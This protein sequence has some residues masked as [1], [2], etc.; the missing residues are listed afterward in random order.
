MQEDIIVMRGLHL[1]ENMTANPARVDNHAKARHKSTPNV[2]WSRRGQKELMGE[3]IGLSPDHPLVD[4]TLKNEYL[5]DGD[6]AERTT[7]RKQFKIISIMVDTGCA[8]TIIKTENENF[9]MDSYPSPAVISGFQGTEKVKGGVRG[10]V[11]LY[12][13][14]EKGL[15]ANEGG[16][17]RHQVDTLE[18]LNMNLLSLSNLYAREDYDMVI[19]AKSTGLSSGFTKE[20]PNGILNHLPM[21]WDAEAGAFKI[22]FLMA[23]N[24]RDAISWGRKAE[25]YMKTKPQSIQRCLM[26]NAG[27]TRR[28]MYGRDQS[29]TGVNVRMTA[30]KVPNDGHG[31]K[32][33]K[34]LGIHVHKPIM[35][36]RTKCSNEGSMPGRQRTCDCKFNTRF[37]KSLRGE[38][39]PWEDQCY[40]IREDSTRKDALSYSSNE[41]LNELESRGEQTY[42]RNGICAYVQ[43]GVRIT[44]SDDFTARP[45]FVSDYSSGSSD[46]AEDKI[47]RAHV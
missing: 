24:K 20:G 5:S 44:V 36:H 10:T 3:E 6:H 42:L 39:E 40:E 30:Y 17:L 8:S 9:V 34:H 41:F 14:D 43:D 2:G 23:S 33:R 4:F 29:G 28:A 7:R 16:Y 22:H 1:E 19:P 45:A 46:T 27:N 18:S 12:A 47:G 32:A 21:A 15:G 11:H 13:L 25:T 35:H 31:K 38:F 26:N 37:T